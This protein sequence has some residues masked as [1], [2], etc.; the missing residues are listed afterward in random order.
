MKT[1]KESII[2]KKGMVKKLPK[3]PEYCTGDFHPITSGS[4]FSYV[5]NVDLT[6]RYSFELDF[7]DLWMELRNLLRIDI[8][9]VP[10][11]ARA[12]FEYGTNRQLYGNPIGFNMLV[13][14]VPIS[15][16]AGHGRTRRSEETTSRILPG[17]DDYGGM[18]KPMRLLVEHNGY[19]PGKYR[20][21]DID[22]QFNFSNRTKKLESIEINIYL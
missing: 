2:G 19:I 14:N 5:F 10:N 4:T 9:G 18:E 6:K 15:L 16:V 17:L 3:L 21:K 7:I 12:L 13:K 11:P 20:Y 1:I 8:P 22:L